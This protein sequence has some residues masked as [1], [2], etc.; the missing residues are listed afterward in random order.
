ML[1]VRSWVKGQCEWLKKDRGVAEMGWSW[2]DWLGL[3]KFKKLLIFY[4]LPKEISRFIKPLQIYAFIKPKE[5]FTNEYQFLPKHHIKVISPYPD[6]PQKFLSN[7]LVISVFSYI[8]CLIFD[9]FMYETNKQQVFEET[10]FKLLF[11][12]KER[13]DESQKE[14]PLNSF[15]WTYTKWNFIW[16]FFNLNGNLDFYRWIS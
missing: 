8:C 16:G 5:S 12:N 10:K 13:T 3:G 2:N 9:N 15:I 11:R 14:L 7:K 4:T 1:I 6:Y